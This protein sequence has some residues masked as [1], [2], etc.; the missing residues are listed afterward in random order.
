[1]TNVGVGFVVDGAGTASWG[2]WTGQLSPGASM[3]I[4]ATGGPQH[5]YWV[6]TPGSHTLVATVDDVNRFPESVED[7]NAYTA[8]FFVNSPPAPKPVITGCSLT[9]GMA[10]ITWTTTA[11]AVYVLE[12]SDGLVGNLWQS[13]DPV[14]A[15]STTMQYQWPG[16]QGR[17]FFR[18][19]RFD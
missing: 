16:V 17:K 7:N 9:N 10:T 1:L 13:V 2:G 11:G 5:Y 19:V 6:A 8:N 18:V 12:A 4:T 3:L 15:T 14:R